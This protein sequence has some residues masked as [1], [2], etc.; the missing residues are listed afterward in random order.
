MRPVPSAEITTNLDHADAGED[1]VHGGEDGLVL[2]PNGAYRLTRR[3]GLAIS[4]STALLGTSFE[5][6]S[7]TPQALP[8]GTE[9]RRG[10]TWSPLQRP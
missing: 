7:E 10:N 4:A 1:H 8:S 6:R 3:Q 5:V 2:G 9:P